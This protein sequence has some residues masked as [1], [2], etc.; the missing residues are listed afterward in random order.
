MACVNVPQ[1]YVTDNVFLCLQAHL[2]PSCACKKGSGCA[3]FLRHKTQR[4]CS[5]PSLHRVQLFSDDLLRLFH[6]PE[7][8]PVA[9]NQSGLWHRYR[10]VGIASGVMALKRML[11]MKR[12]V[13]SNSP[14]C[15][16]RTQARHDF[17]ASAGQRAPVAAI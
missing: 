3:F 13:C 6:Q 5:I 12:P 8:V 14:A 10:A 2:V 1:I 7:I 9:L 16:P 17:G 4:C 15:P 11:Q